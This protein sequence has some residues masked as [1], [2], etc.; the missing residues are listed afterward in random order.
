M[1]R[2]TYLRDKD[3]KEQQCD[4]PCAEEEGGTD[5]Q[6]VEQGQ[7]QQSGNCVERI[8]R[9]GGRDRTQIHV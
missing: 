6:V 7:V 4:V 2:Y 8:V 3:P 1:Y 5:P 9:A